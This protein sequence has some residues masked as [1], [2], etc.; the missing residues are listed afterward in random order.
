MGVPSAAASCLFRSSGARLIQLSQRSCAIFVLLFCG[1]CRAA[2]AAFG[3]PGGQAYALGRGGRVDHRD[4]I[5]A[6]LPG[7]SLSVGCVGGLR[8]GRGVGGYGEVRERAA[9]QKRGAGVEG[10]VRYDDI[11]SDAFRASL[12]SSVLKHG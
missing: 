10:G 8:G 6:H 9:S 3:A 5:V 12:L 7:G 11:S 4:R 2:L 1:D